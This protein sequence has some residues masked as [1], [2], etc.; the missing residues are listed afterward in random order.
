MDVFLTH[1]S[2]LAELRRNPLLASTP[3]AFR[4]ELGALETQLKEAE[5]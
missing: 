1:K 3:E 5:K 4:A 2:L